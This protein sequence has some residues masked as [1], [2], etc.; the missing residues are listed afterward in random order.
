MIDHDYSLSE[1]PARP[2]ADALESAIDPSGGQ[3]ALVFLMYFNYL[4]FWC[5]L[6]TKIIQHVS[7]ANPHGTDRFQSTTELDISALKSSPTKQIRVSSK[8]HED[9]HSTRFKC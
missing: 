1:G 9:N 8:L 3:K 5:P 2:V 7:N 4:P 6:A